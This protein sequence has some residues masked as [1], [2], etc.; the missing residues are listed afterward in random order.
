MR[1]TGVT[2]AIALASLASLVAPQ[3]SAQRGMG[4]RGMGGRGMGMG[5]DSATAAQMATIHDLMMSHE[6]IKRTVANLPNGVRTVTESD[7]PRIATLIKKHALDMT[8]RVGAGSDPGWPMESPAVRTIFR[9]QALV[10]TRADTT[11][12]GILVEQISTDSLTVV[13][14]QRHAAEVTDLVREGMA[15]MH[16]AMMSGMTHDTSQHAMHADSAFAAMQTR[17]KQAMG[18]DQYT[19]T[20]QFEAASDGGRIELQRDVDD[21]ADVAQIREHLQGI[22]KAF[23]DGDFS[24]PAFVHLGDV[25]G[26]K[27]MAAKRTVITYTFRPLPRGGELRIRSTDAQAIAAI[28]EF[29][30]FQRRE[31]RPS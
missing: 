1:H 4:G 16:R 2:F 19:S 23:S 29:L 24:T 17:G 22:A 7:D 10:R 26:A 20:H 8:A 12:A 27:V 14:L 3:A 30:A 15:A 13:A 31:H 21:S 25:P 9:N 18:V 6:R 11:A 28:H 5:R